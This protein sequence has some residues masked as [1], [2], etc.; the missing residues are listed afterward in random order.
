M[1]RF[2]RL[3]SAAVLLIGECAIASASSD[4]SNTTVVGLSINKT[5][6]SFVFIKVAGTPP[7]PFACSTNGAWHYTLPLATT[8]DRQ[9]YAMLLA[10]FLNGTTV[11]M[12]GLGACNEYG[13]IESL[14]SLTVSD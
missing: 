12:A 8:A 2:K 4:I 3:F 7:S 6:G 1:T 14:G 5:Y 13:T 11:H 10:A 9:L